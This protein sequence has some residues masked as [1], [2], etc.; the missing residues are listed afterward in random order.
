MITTHLLRMSRERAG[1]DV[2]GAGSGRLH[3]D[4]PASGIGNIEKYHT[5][6]RLT[7]NGF[8][9]CLSL[10]SLH[11]IMVRSGAMRSEASRWEDLHCV[12][13]CLSRC[14]NEVHLLLKC[15]L[16]SS[17]GYCNNPRRL[18]VRPLLNLQRDEHIRYEGYLI[19]IVRIMR[20]WI[21]TEQSW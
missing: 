13:H 1:E 21:K 14:S 4:E 10:N 7:G 17:K 3:S 15:S 16:S 9:S 12:L 11:H 6:K 2:I 8:N 18:L 19:R 20:I 5:T